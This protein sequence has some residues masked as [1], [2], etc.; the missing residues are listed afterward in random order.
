MISMGYKPQMHHGEKVYCK[1]EAVMGS[2]TQMTENCKTLEELKAQTQN[3]R[4]FTE[5][6]QRLG[7]PPGK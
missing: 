2:R 5:N 4:Q 7:V 6:S 1:R 3:S